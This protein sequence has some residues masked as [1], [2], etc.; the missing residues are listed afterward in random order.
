MRKLFGQIM[1]RHMCAAGRAVETQAFLGFTEVAPDQVGER[2]RIERRIRLEEIE[3][4]EGDD[5]R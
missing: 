4:V 1:V 2:L 3:V 5:A